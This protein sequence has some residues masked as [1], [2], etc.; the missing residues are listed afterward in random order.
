MVSLPAW[1]GA[2]P[3]WLATEWLRFRSWLVK[4]RN[5]AG[6]IPVPPDDGP[7]LVGLARTRFG[8]GHPSSGVTAAWKKCC[9]GRRLSPQ[10][11][12]ARFSVVN[13]MPREAAQ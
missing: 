7:F 1:G 2:C 9:E 10:K 13:G 6:R 4:N 12:G 8:L 5:Y 11:G 3:V